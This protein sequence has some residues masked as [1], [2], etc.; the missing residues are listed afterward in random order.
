M[1]TK[2][3]RGR[4]ASL[5]CDRPTIDCM[6]GKE[7]GRRMSGVVSLGGPPA[8]LRDLGPLSVA[9]RTHLP[10]NYAEKAAM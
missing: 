8:S 6:R 4:G 9:Y 5:G 2:M 3:K 7:E 10:V 1:M